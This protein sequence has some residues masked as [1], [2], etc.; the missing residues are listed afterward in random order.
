MRHKYLVLASAVA[1]AAASVSC[2]KSND[3]IGTWTSDV[4]DNIVADVP[5]ATRAT[6]TVT[7]SFMEQP[8]SKDSGPVALT[9]VIDAS[10]PVSAI[11]SLGVAQPYEANI[12][13]TA[14]LGGTWMR[15]DDDDLILNFDLNTLQVNVDN[16]SVTFS[17]NILT[18]AQQPVIDSMTNATAAQWKAQ[19][20]TAVKKQFARYRKL[21]DV[22]LRKD[23]SLRF[24]I[25]NPEAKV[26]FRPAQ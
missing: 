18:N 22:E 23:G 26:T 16:N 24:E 3:F 10:Q 25:E 1:L 7:I 15:E 8:G 4:P 20:A 11:D 13:A 17:Q 14:N 2:S 6:S 19:L 9:S 21:D 12:A 5:A